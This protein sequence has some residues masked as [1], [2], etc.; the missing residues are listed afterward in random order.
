MPLEFKEILDEGAVSYV[1]A[2]PTTAAPAVDFDVQ[3]TDPQT[4]ERYAVSFRQTEL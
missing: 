1:A 3:L 4:G 2:F